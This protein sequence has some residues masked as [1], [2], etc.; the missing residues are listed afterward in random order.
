VEQRSVFRRSHAGGG[1]R[2]AYPPY[3]PALS[4]RVNVA[5]TW[6]AHNPARESLL[7]CETMWT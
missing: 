4:A 6:S 2:C 5:L 1:L 7:A 3:G